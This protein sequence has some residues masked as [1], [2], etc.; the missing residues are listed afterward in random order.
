MPLILLGGDCLLTDC[1]VEAH[2]CERK[3]LET[4]RELAGHALCWRGS[5]QADAVLAVRC[6]FYRSV[7]VV[8]G[9][10]AAQGPFHNPEGS[11]TAGRS[12]LWALVLDNLEQNSRRHRMR[13][14]M[15]L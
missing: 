9:R 14:E 6:P 13:R 12:A 11:K 1:R 2:P 10:D 8:W 3:T 15:E 5:R 7:H 4:I